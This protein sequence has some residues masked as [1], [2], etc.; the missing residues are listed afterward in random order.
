MIARCWRGATRREDADEYVAFLERTGL[1][2]YQATPGNRGVLAL[3][4]VGAERAEFVLFSFW[5]SLA[6][7]RAFAGPDIERAVFYPED[8]RFLVER[9]PT[10]AHYEVTL[11]TR[12]DRD[13][14]DRG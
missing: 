10:V 5:D 2:E 9:G 8:D 3:R 13:A 4:R 7:V 14:M 6:A 1:A 11:D 12:A